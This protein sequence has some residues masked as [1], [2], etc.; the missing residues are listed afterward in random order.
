MDSYDLVITLDC[1]NL[2]RTGLAAELSRRPK[3]QYVIEIDHHPKLDEYSDLEL[4]YPWSSSTAEL[5]YYFI[6]ANKIKFNKN[7]ANCVLTGIL[8]DTGN[9]L[10]PSTSEK[11]VKIASEMLVYGARFPR[12]IENTW[13]NKSLSAMKIWGKALNNL[14]I[15]PRYRIGYTVLTRDEIASSGATEEDLEGISG[16]LSNLEGIRALLVLREE[17]DGRLK[18]SLRTTKPDVDV[19]LLAGFLGGG[20]HSKAAG[21]VVDSLELNKL[22]E[23]ESEYRDNNV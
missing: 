18:G 15:N 21:F 23:P 9:F 19:S 22:L 5:V 8:T 20:G 4:R 13:R 16:F 14:K 11:T 7:L 10:Y 3:H 12:I 2:S 1:S 17:S 6:K